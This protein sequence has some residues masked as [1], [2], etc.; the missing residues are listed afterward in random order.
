MGASGSA[1]LGSPFPELVTLADLKR[2]L[3]LGGVSSPLSDA[4]VD[5]Q[6]KLDVAHELVL[7]KVA[8]RVT[9]GLLWLAVVATWDPDTAP[10]VVKLA[11]LVQATE[12]WR[13]LGDEEWQQARAREPVESQLSPTVLRLINLLRDPVLS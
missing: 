11:I 12:F 8:E 10:R 7:A 9:D 6:T 2:H 5:L 13:F 1:M 3:R 4:D